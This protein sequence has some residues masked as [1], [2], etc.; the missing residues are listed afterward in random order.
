MKAFLRKEWMEMTRTGRLLIL[1][2]IFILF[3]IMNPAIA[4]LTPALLNMMKDSI[5]QSGMSVGEVTVNAMS[6]WTQYYKNAP[7]VLIVTV[8]MSGSVLVGEYQSGTLIQVVTK[9]LSRRK[10]FLS[11]AITLLGS[12]TVLFLLYFG[13]T[14]AYTASLWSED[15]VEHLLCGTAAYWLFGAFVLAFMLL[16]S[17]IANNSGQVLLGTGIVMVVILFLNYTPKLQKYLPFRLMDGLQLCAGTLEAGDFTAAAVIAS[18]CVVLC[19]TGGM[20]L[21]DRKML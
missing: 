15:R 14:Y 19:I 12:W 7:I 8:L 21:F 6:S 11:K 20:L 2:V 13:I 16:F 5:A 18:I 10:I 17:A 9:G 4:K 3:A 1:T